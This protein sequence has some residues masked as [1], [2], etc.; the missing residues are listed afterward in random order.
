MLPSPVPRAGGG[1]V[2]KEVKQ[3]AGKV[4]GGGDPST[5]RHIKLPALMSHPKQGSILCRG[6]LWWWGRGG[7]AIIFGQL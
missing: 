1:V 2:G 4:G 3:V 5:P 7:G 6:V